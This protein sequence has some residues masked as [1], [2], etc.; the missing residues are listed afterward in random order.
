MGIIQCSHDC[1]HQS[2]GYCCL[3]EQTIIDNPCAANGIS[4]VHYKQRD[5]NT[6]L[7]PVNYI[8]YKQ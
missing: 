2:E 8:E 1:I 4:C 3:E 6:M 7:D 5:D